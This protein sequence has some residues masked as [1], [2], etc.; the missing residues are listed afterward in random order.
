MSKWNNITSVKK[1]I[2][3]YDTLYP[4]TGN[5]SRNEYNEV[6]IE[7]SQDFTVYY[8]S[9]STNYSLAIE[10]I[11]TDGSGVIDFYISAD[12]VNFSTLKAT[13]GVTDFS[14]SYDTADTYE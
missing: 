10:R 2:A 12:G 1:D 14:I 3:R 9:L 6:L 11:G 5:Y 4:D 13:D 8:Q 7:A